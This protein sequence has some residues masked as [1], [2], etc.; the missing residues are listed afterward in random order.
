MSWVWVL[1][2]NFFSKCWMQVQVQEVN[3]KLRILTGKWAWMDPNWAQLVW[4]KTQKI[5][6]CKIP[7]AIH[8]KTHTI[9]KIYTRTQNAQITQ[10]VIET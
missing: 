5:K 10:K 9:L 6:V 2:W 7:Y 4:V 3:I 8:Q 1:K